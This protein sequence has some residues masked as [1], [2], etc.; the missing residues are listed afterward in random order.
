MQI[1]RVKETSSF[2]AAVRSVSPPDSIIHVFT[3]DL[4]TLDSFRG[5]FIY[6]PGMD[7]LILVE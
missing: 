6:V 2:I 4:I 7:V 1:T 5:L 3:I